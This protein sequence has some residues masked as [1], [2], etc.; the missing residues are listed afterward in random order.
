M[1][2]S[3]SVC[4]RLDRSLMMD[5][6]SQA[7]SSPRL[8]SHYNF[9]PSPDSAVNR[10]GIALIRGTY[11]RP[12][13]HP[14]PNKW[15]SIIVLWGRV[16][17]FT[18]DSQ[19]VIE[20]LFELGDASTQ[21][22]SLVEIPAH[23]WHS[24]IPMT[25]QAFIFEFKEGPYAPLESENFAAWSPAEYAAAAPDFLEWASTAKVGDRYFR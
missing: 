11:V 15:E 10:L 3:N 2:E 5:L 25:Q 4:A 20:N 23:T 19:G 9:H 8:R 17:V 22:D 7:S 21:G 13:R 16:R 18:Y 1:N 14:E 24:L 6:I 12:H